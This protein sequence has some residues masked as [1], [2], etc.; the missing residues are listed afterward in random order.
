MPVTVWDRTLGDALKKSG[1]GVYIND[2]DLAHM[3][4]ISEF[5]RIVSA[6]T[7]PAQ[8]TQAGMNEAIDRMRRENNLSIDGDNAYKR[9]LLDC[10]IGALAFGKQ[11]TTPPPEGH[12]L[13][14]FWEIG[15]AER[16]E[17]DAAPPAQQ[18]QAATDV[19]A[20]RRRQ[21]E[22][23]GWTPEHDDAHSCDEIAAFACF[24]AMPPA[25]RD[26]DATSTG[27]AE[28]LGEAIKPDGWDGKTGDRRRELVKAGALI[29]AEIER[30]DRADKKELSNV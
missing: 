10:V 28:T 16:K 15:D 29:L 4:A 2:S 30:L 5:A 22:V 8:P 24:Y 3:M 1:L 7:P 26:W 18:S 20:E 21:I 19:L 9:D 13:H 6:P 23:E 25:A 14:Q 12:W 17:R 11:G 27:Y